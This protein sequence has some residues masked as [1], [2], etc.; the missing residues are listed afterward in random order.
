VRGRVILQHRMGAEGLSLLL[1]PLT[2]EVMAALTNKEVVICTLAYL[3]LKP[4]LKASPLV[5]TK[6]GAYKGM[7]ITY[8]MLMAL[9]SALA[10]VATI[11]ALGWDRGRMQWLR[12]LT[13][14]T[15]AP[16]WT[17]ACPSP[18][19]ESKLFMWAAWSF[20]YSK[21]V[22]YLDTA[23]L[24]LKGRPVSF[25][26]TVHHF[27][28][29]WDVFLGIVLQN[30]GIWIFMSFNA[31]IHTVMYTYYAIAAAGVSY[32]AKP[33]ITAMQI[34][35]FLSGFYVVLPYI[36][37]PCFRRSQGMVFSWVFNYV[38]VGTVL[39]LFL[40]FFYSDNF[41]AKKAARKATRKKD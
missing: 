18:V 25:L 27:G 12:D 11:T 17:D 20:Y 7:M 1:E 41:G 38:Y 15:I 9:Y 19:F 37:V 6:K 31:F 28:A 36:N 24:V 30:E 29:P 32:P 10:F 39:A 22:E 26:Q 23:W 2:P 14:D 3:L 34:T 33:L 40:H 5:S 8:N 21:Y 13:G 35:Q 4:A 16:L